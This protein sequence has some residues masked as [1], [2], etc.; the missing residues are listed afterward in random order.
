MMKV[1]ENALMMPC[2]LSSAHTWK[3][4][5]E[6]K[7]TE[8]FCI[9]VSLDQRLEVT[10]HKTGSKCYAVNEQHLACYM[11]LIYLINSLSHSSSYCVTE[12][13]L[14]L[15]HH[16][17]HLHFTS[18]SQKCVT[19]DGIL[20][21]EK[22]CKTICLPITTPMGSS[23]SSPLHPVIRFQAVPRAVQSL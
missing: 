2:G 1:G 13:I 10:K 6:K 3:F 20:S 8:M 22:P 23:L 15:I 4:V 12:S 19:A 18:I 9:L 21:G 11:Q 5:N 16:I 17:I 14:I 7:G